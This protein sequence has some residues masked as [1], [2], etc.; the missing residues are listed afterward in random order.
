MIV[1]AAVKSLPAEQRRRVHPFLTGFNPTDKNADAHIRRMLELDPTLAGHRRDLYPSRRPHRADLRRRA[2]GQQRGAGAG[3]S[4]GRRIRPAGV[5]ARQ[6]HFQARTQPAVPGGNRG[7]PAQSPACAV[8]LG[9]CR[10]QHGDPSP[11]EETGLPPADPSASATALPEPLHRP[12]LVGVAPVPAGRAG[13]ARSAVAGTGRA[14]S[15]TLHARFRC[16]RPVRQPARVDGEL[17]SVPR[18]LA[19]AGR[20][21]GG[22]DNF[23]A[24]LPRQPADPRG[25]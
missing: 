6:R 13:Q 4:P 8:H 1:A 22:A 5:A 3:L 7:A 11:P 18:R 2:E 10:D 24:V 21:P 9:P 17:R 15:A 23:L 19:R 25:E 20:S 16:G 14:V 12:V